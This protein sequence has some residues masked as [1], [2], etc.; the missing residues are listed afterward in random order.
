MLVG[1]AYGQSTYHIRYD[2]VKIG[3]GTGGPGEL[4][5]ESSTKDTTS[6]V[7]VNIGGGKTQFKKIRAISATQFVVGTDTVTITGSGGG[8]SGTL[9]NLTATDNTGQT[10]TITNPTT[11]PNLSLALTSAAVGLGNVD[12]TSDANKPV[13][14]ATSTALGLKQDNI[15]LTTTGSSGAATLVGATLNIPQYTSTATW[16]S[17]TGTLSSQTDLQTAIDGKVADAL[18][19]GTTTIAPSQNAVYDAIASIQY[20][21]PP[22]EKIIQLLGSVTLY[23]TLGQ[24]Q[25]NIAVSAALADGT[26][27]FVAI[28]ITEQTTITGVTWWQSVAGD[29]TAD[30]YNGVA[31]YSYSAGTITLVASST[32]DGNIWKQTVAT[33]GSKNFSSTYAAAPGIYFVGYL[34]NTSAQ[35]TAPSIGAYT[36]LV[37]A[38]IPSGGL[39]NSAKI[40][41]QLA[42]Q[43]A[44]PSP[45]AMSGLTS[46]V[47]QLYGAL[48]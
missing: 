3:K 14:T 48:Y 7:L 22:A 17:I 1:I 36:T 42:T 34:Y 16:G 12:N 2:T 9:T 43:T 8:G 37:N 5:L 27:R 46:N 47:F 30:N 19:N 40:T 28:N 33:F 10:W 44:F 18:T 35:T 13:S 32:N 26:A 15:T 4:V 24:S 29:Y 20:V 39:T 41:S 23:E 45:Q 38:G 31:L 11:T 6:G 25:G 21:R